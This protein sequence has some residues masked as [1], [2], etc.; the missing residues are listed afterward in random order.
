[1]RL[2]ANSEQKI[3]QKCKTCILKIFKAWKNKYCAYIYIYMY[4]YTH[5]QTYGKST[6]R[7]KRI[8]DTKFGRMVTK[9]KG[10]G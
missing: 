8:F 4:R 9:G 6:K 2:K 7:T 3:A 1:M 10:R 5:I